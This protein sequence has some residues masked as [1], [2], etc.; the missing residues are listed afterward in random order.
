MTSLKPNKNEVLACRFSSWYSDFRNINPNTY[1]I[2][3]N[4]TVYNNVTMKSII[5]PLPDVF[6]IDY[7]SSDGVRLPIGA[8]KLSSC[9]PPDHNNE[10]EEWS[11]EDEEND[12]KG[13]DESESIEQFHFPKL[14]EQ[15]T[16]AI[17]KL[18][19]SSLPKLNWSSP[20]DAKWVN[21]GTLKCQTAG[22]VYLLLKSSDFIMYDVHHAMNDIRIEEDLGCET[23]SME[24][25]YEL[26]LRKWCNLYDSMEFRCFVSNHQLVAISQRNH[27]QYYLH[28]KRD[29]LTLRSHINDFFNQYVQHKFAKGYVSNYVFDCYIEKS[30]RVW[31]LDFNVWAER[32]DALLFTWEELA[33]FKHTIDNSSEIKNKAG[34]EI[35][36]AEEDEIE[37]ENKNPEMR[38]VLSEYEVH[39]DPLASFR[40][41]IDTIDLAAD[42]QGA[43]SFEEFMKMCVKPSE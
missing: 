21:E 18:G 8:T 22:D 38:I 10:Y 17:D 24:S 33:T 13:S 11:S 5:I 28:L 35:G 23:T 20:K 39:Y 40:A 2:A 31:I 36:N 25:K 43:N 37:I 42:K 7:L 6:V 3:N 12:S 41:P 27:T 30:N 9:A 19:G 32:T 15:I 29:N 1:K 4:G 14:N 34:S 26:V 16:K